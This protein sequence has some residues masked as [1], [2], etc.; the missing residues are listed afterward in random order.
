MSLSE[1]IHVIKGYG[2]Y[3]SCGRHIVLASGATPV[4]RPGKFSDQYE[5]MFNP[6]DHSNR[7]GGGMP[8]HLRAVSN[9]ANGFTV[10]YLA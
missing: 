1:L 10:L 6:T 9:F 5:L 8:R 3:P 2:V 7:P 4:N